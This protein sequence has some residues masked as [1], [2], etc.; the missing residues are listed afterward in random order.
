MSPSAKRPPRLTFR[1]NTEIAIHVPDLDQAEGF[2]GRVLSF[3]SVARSGE[4]LELDTGAL[5]LY[6]NRDGAPRS[7]VPSFDVSDHAAAQRHLKEAGC[8][9]VTVL[10]GGNPVTY[11]LDPFGFAFD[12]VQRR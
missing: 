7:F 12:I 3:R 4:Q 9:T 1:S 8:S 6:V 2:Y 10:A 5:R 11:F